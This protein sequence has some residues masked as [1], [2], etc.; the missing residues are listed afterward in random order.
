MENG[1]SGSRF[2]FLLLVLHHH[3]KPDMWKELLLQGWGYHTPLPVEEILP[4]TRNP[5]PSLKLSHVA[6]GALWFFCT[7]K[8]V[9]ACY[10]YCK[11]FLLLASKNGSHFNNK[12]DLVNA[13]TP[14]EVNSH[15]NFS[16]WNKSCGNFHPFVLS[17]PGCAVSSLQN[18]QGCLWMELL[19]RYW[20][21]LSTA[22]LGLGVLLKGTW[23]L[24]YDNEDP[25]QW[26]IARAG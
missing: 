24:S 2:P 5:L 13:Y 23:I 25:R 17:C 6:G 19:E 21:P 18:G 4:P 11:H 7:T 14:T 9:L 15:R 8:P 16:V 20:E 1:K 12:I 22:Q 3:C 26:V 10:F